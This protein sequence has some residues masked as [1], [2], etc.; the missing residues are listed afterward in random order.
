MLMHDNLVY[1]QYKKLSDQV[2]DL[3]DNELYTATK[4]FVKKGITVTKE[5]GDLSKTYFNAEIDHKD[6]SKSVQSA[7]DI[8][9]YIANTTKNMITDVVKAEWLTAGTILILVNAVYFKGV[10]EKE[11]DPN[12]TKKQDFYLTGNNKIQVDM[13]NMVH[14]VRYMKAES[15]SAIALP[16]TG[17]K[18]EMVLVLP[19]Y[20]NGLKDLKQSFS[21]A[22][23]FN[24][25]T[26]LINTSVQIQ[27]PKFKFESATNLKQ[28]LPKL[29][30]SDIFIN[31]VADFTN[32]VREIK[33]NIFVSEARH[34]VVIDVN[35]KG[36]EAAAVTVIVPI[37]GGPAGPRF[38]ADH[39]FLFYIRH[40][41][42]GSILFLGHFNPS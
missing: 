26:N 33:E 37:G 13:M 11:F 14:H 6:F 27:L 40:V 7:K 12:L 25:D 20:I 38:I 15:Y 32:L 10:W 18:Y 30:V 8:N 5:V 21:P 36:T 29:G 19:N 22:M 23:V 39:P 3:T 1:Q 28:L 42:T 41:S 2:F 34:K 31:G 9:L 4:L 16:Y 17:R 24:I 35:E